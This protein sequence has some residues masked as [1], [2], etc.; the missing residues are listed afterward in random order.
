VSKCFE[1][2][3][4]NKIAIKDKEKANC[5]MLA[6]AINRMSQELTGKK[7]DDLRDVMGELEEANGM[8]T[9][10]SFPC[11]TLSAVEVT[12]LDMSE[13]DR[14]KADY[15]LKVERDSTRIGAVERQCGDVTWPAPREKSVSL[16][17]DGERWVL[18]GR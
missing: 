4:D 9:A 6:A 8:V 5:L 15:R 13:P 12:K 11:G 1:A 14:L 18:P 10:I 16:F 7:P 17:K 3:V 2:L